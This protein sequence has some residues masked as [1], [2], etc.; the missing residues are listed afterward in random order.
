MM[1]N[2]IDADGAAFA[3][4][5]IIV[6]RVFAAAGIPVAV[7]E[8][9]TEQATRLFAATAAGGPLDSVR[10]SASWQGRRDED[11]K[12]WVRLDVSVEQP[13]P[14]VFRVLFD[15]SRDRVVL[16]LAGKRRAIA[17]ISRE[18]HEQHLG[19]PPLSLLKRCVAIM[20]IVGSPVA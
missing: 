19:A 4:G 6:D 7:V 16:D 12:E 2:S 3:A 17:L 11:A 5:A 18:E 15:A 14:A 8:P 13:L 9:D 10:S 20:D 1:N